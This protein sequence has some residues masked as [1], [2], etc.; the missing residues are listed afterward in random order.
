M[1]NQCV[2]KS[3]AAQP[4]LRVFV[5]PGTYP[6][7]PNMQTGAEDSPFYDL[8]DAFA[9]INEN[10]APYATREAFI[11]LEKGTHYITLRD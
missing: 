6:S 4:I 3:D 9:F 10:T 8:R 1:G 7:S 2:A 11:Y 5:A